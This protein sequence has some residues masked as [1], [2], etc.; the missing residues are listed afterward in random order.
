MAR[1]QHALGRRS[2]ILVVQ[3]PPAAAAL[4][5]REVDSAVATALERAGKAGIRGSAATPFLL[6]EVDH[7]T[8]GR[9][10]GANLALL[11]SNAGLAA[12]IAVALAT[13]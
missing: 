3:P 11:E 6:A 5:W 8:A 13:G 2:S 10:R 7:A 12:E 9:S 1:A 4:P